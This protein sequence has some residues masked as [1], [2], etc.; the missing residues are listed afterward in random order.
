[1]VIR[2]LARLLLLLVC[3]HTAG[4]VFSAALWW[5]VDSGPWAQDP[6]LV[7]TERSDT[8]AV[9]VYGDHP[10]RDVSTAAERTVD[11]LTAAG[12]FDRSVLVV[13]LPTGSGWVDPAQVLATERW[14]G[15]DVAT[16]SV[17]YAAAPSAAAYLLRPTLAVDSARALLS[18]VSEH[19][20]TMPPADRPSLVVHGQSLGALA[21]ERAL[22]G[23]SLA[24]HVDTRIWQGRPGASARTVSPTADTCAVSAVNADD[25]VAALTWDLLGRPFEAVEVL[26][27]L[28]GSA[29]ANPGTLHSYTPVIPASVC[30]E[31]PPSSAPAGRS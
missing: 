20:D 17:R 27:A 19:L 12:G 5:S 15:G 31:R 8:G 18:E 21:G 16:V 4:P 14:A 30:V 11:D 22:T 1:M 7:L 9:R 10:D 25:P 3:L 23:D 24:R 13:A 6:L 28:P 2:R 26:A 29:S